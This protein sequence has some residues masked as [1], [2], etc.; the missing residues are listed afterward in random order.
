MGSERVEIRDDVHREG[1]AGGIRRSHD[2]R[3]SLGLE[4][5]G[6]YRL[7]ATKYPDYPALS[8]G[9]DTDPPLPVWAELAPSEQRDDLEAPLGELDLSRPVPSLRR[10][11]YWE[12]CDPNGEE[13]FRHRIVAWDRQVEE[14]RLGRRRHLDTWNQLTY[15]LSSLDRTGMG[16]KLH[17]TLGTYVHSLATSEALAPEIVEAFCAWPDHDPEEVWPRL[18]RRA[19]LHERVTDPVADGRHRSCAIGVSTLTL[20]RVRRLGFDGY[21]MFLSPDSIGTASRRRRYHVVPSGMFQPFADESEE[22]PGGLRAR[23]SVRSTVVREFVEEFYG[24]EALDTGDGRVDQSAIV[25]RPE[26][27]VLTEMLDRGDAQ[28]LYSGVAVNLLTLRPEICTALIVHDPDW[29]DE[30]STFLRL[31]DEDLRKIEPTE[32]LP[33]QRWI[34]TI[35]LSNDHL[36]PD[37][38]WRDALR[39]GTLVPPAWAAV[40]LGLRVARDQIL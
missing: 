16:V 25:R 35:G 33:D 38:A 37:P 39:A 17:C 18:E 6:L 31:A 23:F 4:S 32:P 5:R 36:E 8:L 11:E 34:R 22:S 1:R 7:L 27:R 13:E 20:V 3:H 2:E 29:Y 30:Q 40:D 9:N 10:W 26:A 12:P 28:L 19:W 15:D 14:T 24:V 21:R